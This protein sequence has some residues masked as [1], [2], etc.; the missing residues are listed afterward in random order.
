MHSPFR[1][2]LSFLVC[3]NLKS[4]SPSEFI[5]NFIT[6]V[7]RL[8]NH[9]DLATSVLRFLLNTRII[10][11]RTRLGVI[12]LNLNTST[13]SIRR[14]GSHCREHFPIAENAVHIPVNVQGNREWDSFWSIFGRMPLSQNRV[15]ASPTLCFQVER[16][17]RLAFPHSAVSS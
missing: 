12:L 2:L 5:F 10:P 9:L 4:F 13:I 11:A 1:I 16:E 15:S 6:Q 3:G 14:L 17:T 8:I 7:R